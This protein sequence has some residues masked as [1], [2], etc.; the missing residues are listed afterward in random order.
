MS[1][2]T[3]EF[4]TDT[5]GEFGEPVE[6]DGRARAAEGLRRGDQRQDRRARRGRHRLAGLLD[7]PGLPGR[8]HGERQ[9]DPAAS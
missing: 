4:R 1:T 3:L 2:T 8:E 6:F 5:L 7:R 9:R